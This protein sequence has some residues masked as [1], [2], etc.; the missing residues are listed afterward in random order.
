MHISSLNGNF[1]IG[2][3]G[4][5][6]RKFVD[7]LSSFGFTWWQV[8]PFCP[9]DECNSPYKSH[10]AFGGNPYFVDLEKL[11]Q[12]GLLTEKEIA[13][14][15]QT[16]SHSCEFDRLKKERISLLKTASGRVTVRDEIEDFIDGRP[17]LKQFC[18]FMALKEANEQKPWTEWTEEK[19]NNNSL[20]LWKFIQYEFFTQW[21]ELK[22]YANSKGIKIMGDVP[23]YVSHDSADVWANKELFLLRE[24]GMPSCVA[25]VPPDYFC[26]DGQLWGNP[27][28][29]WEKMRNDGFSWW[30][31]RVKHMFSMFDGVRIDHFR[32]IESYWSI[33][34]D[35]ETAREGEWK[36]G[37]G[38]EFVEALRSIQG[39][40]IIVAEDLGVIT[41]EVEELVQKSGFPGMKVFQFGFSGEQ[42]SPHA[43][44]NYDS[45][46]VA[47]TGTH[48][49]NT[50]LGYVW[51]IGEYERNVML[52][53]CGFYGEN[54]DNCYDS[55]FRT[56]YQSHARIIIL[57]IQD[58][59]GYGSD[60][61]MNIP[62]RA[63]KNWSF[64]V[65]GEQL[66]GIDWNKF[67]RWNDLYSRNN[68]PSS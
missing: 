1:S 48:D 43:P 41:K 56:V 68:I 45:N 46:T 36:K 54:W 67:S 22:E 35:A 7:F 53:Y 13:S 37:P 24:D 39:A 2:S 59:L 8:L 32:G 4:K 52:E 3:F 28:Y 62:G 21:A 38:M 23:I 47:Y 42:N 58:L 10:G 17:Y 51:E 63:E 6:A 20:F 64:R 40:G 55:I 26:E 61:R 27:I 66:E 11:Y 44:H 65:T 9:V 34:F 31:D 14:A 19:V 49:N 5:E 60:T 16:E 25:G 29:N 57:P 15:E 18:E 30:M 50:L 12:K 33:P